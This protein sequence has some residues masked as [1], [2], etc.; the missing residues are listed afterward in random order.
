MAEIIALEIFLIF[1]KEERALKQAELISMLEK[2]GFKKT[3]CYNQIKLLARPIPVR[4]GV[5]NPLVVEKPR[6]FMDGKSGW[7]YELH[8]GWKEV[9]EYE[10]KNMLAFSVTVHY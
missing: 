2:K 9:S 1:R 3:Y 4:E 10:A 6:A 8:D 7:M 5:A